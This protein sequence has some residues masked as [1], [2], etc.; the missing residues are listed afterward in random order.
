[1]ATR[2]N[3]LGLAL[4]PLI[5]G[6][7]AQYEPAPLRLPY[8][9]YL[10]GVVV[11]VLIVW[12]IHETV[13]EAKPPRAVSLRPRIGVPADIFGQFIAPALT[14]FVS[15]ALMGFYSSL[16]PSLI[17]ESLH[18]RNH[19]TSDAAIF[20]MFCSGV[21]AIAVSRRFSS[22]AVVF[23]ARATLV[24]GVL[25]PVAARELSSLALLFAASAIGGVSGVLGYRGSLA[26][27]NEI[28]PKDRR[29]ETLAVLML[30]CYTGISLPIIGIGSRR[31]RRA[32]APPT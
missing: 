27:V 30:C 6:V 7:L 17:L 13:D 31:K 15:F 26:I 14:A 11:P 18:I 5:S 21:I 22:R 8:L 16:I 24:P 1:M 3:L 12:T 4:G 23:T 29:A 32:Q 20:F 9:V 25:L 19:A 10:V 28:A 2:A